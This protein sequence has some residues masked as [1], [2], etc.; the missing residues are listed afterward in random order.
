MKIIF[1]G[2]LSISGIF[3]DKVKSGEKIICPSLLKI[4]KDSDFVHVNLENPITSIDLMKQRNGTTLKAP[5]ETPFFLKNSNMTICDLAN[6]H[7]LDCGWEGTKDTI[8]ILDE[9]NIQFYGVKKNYIVLSKNNLKIGLIAFYDQGKILRKEHIGPNYEQVF[10]IAKKLKH[11]EKCDFIFLNYHGGSEFNLVP[12]PGKRKKFFNFL[13]SEINVVV[14]HHP[15]VPQGIEYVNKKLLMYSL[16]NFCF[17]LEYHKK[18]KWTDKSFFIECILDK[19]KGLEL[20]QYFYEI[21]LK[22]GIIRLEDKNKK[23]S[24]KIKSVIQVFDDEHTYKNAWLKEAFNTYFNFDNNGY[25]HLK[26]EKQG[27]TYQKNDFVFKIAKSLCM[28]FRDLLKRN[29]RPLLI[30]AVYYIFKK[31]LFKQTLHLVK[32]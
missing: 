2:D 14:G 29:K 27:E 6:N 30:S 19:H 13:K 1:L 21:D 5:V 4:L 15:H 7:I 31:R 18:Y 25:S 28:V 22:N 8:N 3:Y 11:E 17:D 10:K 24:D 20:K 9:K 12:E 16:G 23:F 32:K 26:G